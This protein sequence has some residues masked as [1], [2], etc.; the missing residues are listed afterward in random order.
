MRR[1]ARVHERARTS[2]QAFDD[3][4]EVN[5]CRGFGHLDLIVGSARAG[6]LFKP[7]AVGKGLPS[8][9]V[10]VLVHENGNLVYLGNK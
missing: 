3:R 10:N 4:V 1:V 9:S 7:W 2:E 6:S 5:F 8:G